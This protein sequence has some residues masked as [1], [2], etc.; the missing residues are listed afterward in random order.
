M[1]SA[2]EIEMAGSI[3][4]T[5]AHLLDLLTGEE[6]RTVRSTGSEYPHTFED[7]ARAIATDDDDPRAWAAGLALANYQSA[8][9]ALWEWAVSEEIV[10]ALAQKWFNVRK[11]NLD[12]IG[13]I[14]DDVLSEATWAARR[15][16]SFY[17]PSKGK[18][19]HYAYRPIFQGLDLWLARQSVPVEVPEKIARNGGAPKRAP[20]EEYTDV[21]EIEE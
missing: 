21:W 15:A 20:L 10:V 14:R 19:A 8:V 12:A 17:G 16:V 5:R 6:R 11:P 7:A 18:F 13:A 2:I 9:N 1:I 3:E 4:R